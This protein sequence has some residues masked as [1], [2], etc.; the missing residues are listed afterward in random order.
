M[1]LLSLLWM[2]LLLLFLALQLPSLQ[3]KKRV[4]RDL[5][6]FSDLD[7]GVIMLG[8]E[9]EEEKTKCVGQGETDFFFFCQ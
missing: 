5:D 1:L 6:P 4:R 2:L 7:D 9:K 3:G 8:E